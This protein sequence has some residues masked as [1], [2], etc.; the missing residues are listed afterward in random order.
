M[1]GT[2][3]R[4]LMWAQ[5]VAI[6]LISIVALVLGYAII[7]PTNPL[8]GGKT[9]TARPDDAEGVV[10]GTE[11]TLHGIPVG[12]V[13]DVKARRDGADID[14]R[15]DPGIEVPAD[16]IGVVEAVGAMGGVSLS[17]VSGAA[18]TEVKQRRLSYG[19]RQAA[20]AAPDFSHASGSLDDGA[21]LPMPADA[22][23][24]TLD[25]LLLRAQ[26]TLRTVDPK[27]VG[28][29][30][31]ATEQIIGGR[32]E[33][34]AGFIRN[35]DVITQMLAEQAPT[36][37]SLVT[38]TLP[39]LHEL[40]G[41]DYDIPGT[42]EWLQRMTGQLVQNS[43]SWVYMLEEGAGDMEDIAGMSEALT[44]PF[45]PL[46]VNG[47]TVAKVAADRDPA[48]NSMFVDLPDALNTISGTVRGDRADF[49]LIGAQGPVCFYEVPRRALD[50]P[51]P[52]PPNVNRYCPTT[53]QSG[54]RG[55]ATAPR[56]DSLGMSNWTQPGSISGPTIPPNP[57]IIPDGDEIIGYWQNLLEGI[58]R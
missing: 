29:V 57:L 21:E 24:V 48:M 11:V 55:P 53:E 54:Q 30:V 15:L 41:P 46:L 1:G 22:Q 20:P 19:E 49:I 3:N 8:A 13:T 36:F 43:D 14:I 31:T 23:A 10:S 28:Q 38:G 12:K 47:A 5:A 32:G 4:V 39:A 18:A 26:S 16:A 45:G 52:K 9:L 33:E 17:L 56:P 35:A 2:N 7:A 58:R 34:L 51:G 50:E 44:E 27:D 6:A 40:G 42:A 37:R 25:E